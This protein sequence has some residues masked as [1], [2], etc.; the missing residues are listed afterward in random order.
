MIFA[1][2]P[3]A[4]RLL[5]L[6]LI[7]GPFAMAQDSGWYLGANAGQ[8]RSKID[9]AKITRGLLG[10]GF[11]VSSIDRQDRATGYKVFLGYEFSRYFAFE[12]GYFDLGTFDFTATTAP[13]GTLDGQIKLKGL[14]F[15]AV[16]RVP[17]TERFSAFVRAGV[18]YAEA[19]NS[20]TGTGSVLV[21]NLDPS[22]REAN[23]KFGGGLQYDFTPSF[24]MR[25]EWERYRIKDAVQDKADVDLASAG[26]AVRFGRSSPP[27]PPMSAQ[28]PDQGAVSHGPV[29]REAPLPVVVTAPPKT[30]QY[31]TILDIQ[32][33]IDQD[34]MQREEKEKLGVLGT[35][36]N[37][38][39]ETMAV[40]EGHTDD[41]GTPKHNLDL[42]LRRA[43]SVVA[44][45]VDNLH[46]DR[47]RLKAVGY[48]ALRPVADNATGE[49]KR[50]NRRIN[51]VI[52]CVTDLEGL[53][54][55]PARITLAMLIEFDRNQAE[56]RPEYDGEFHKVARFLKANPSV[57]A[58]VEGHTGNLQATPELSMAI[59]Q[60]RAQNVVNYLVDNF[61]IDRWR[62]SAQGFGE[63][64]RF[65]YNTSAEGAQEN[66]RVNIIIN[67]P[68]RGTN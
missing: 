22:K 41:V 10:A 46:I 5:A 23:A 38:Y 31:C 42:S 68:R 57:T 55:A 12:G 8:S 62:L 60:R 21:P 25:F 67:Y 6:T 48:G 9:D 65:A 56:I 18:N 19:K 20:F 53:K 3:G 58:S 33:E 61:G 34:D 13:P 27:S 66:R 1:R 54:V 2:A 26:L 16:L 37:K 59:S 32:F 50:A 17:M 52:A 39:P 30:Q 36:L 29:A 64:R 43:E 14:N 47:S 7:A 49:G 45:L 4:L 51:A 35:F 24:G 40:I 63:T 15:D 44:Y 28:E 11:T